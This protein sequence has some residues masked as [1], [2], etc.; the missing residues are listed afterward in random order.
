EIATDTV[1]NLASFKLT[2]EADVF[3]ALDSC[4]KQ[5]PS[6]MREYEDT[7]TSLES[8]L[9]P[10]HRRGLGGGFHIYR[11]R[12][13]AR[14]VITLGPNGT[15]ADSIPMMYSVFVTPANTMQ[16]AYDLKPVISYKAEQAVIKGEGMARQTIN[17]KEAIVCT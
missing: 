4:I 2:A 3:I 1:S 8:V 14:S 12:F 5:K 6:W 10:L 9:L 13:P 17:N 16:P 7:K 11:K 15:L